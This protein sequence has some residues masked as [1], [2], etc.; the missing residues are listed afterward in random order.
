MDRR[1]ERHGFI[2]ESADRADQRVLQRAVPGPNADGHLS[3]SA[4]SDRH[5]LTQPASRSSLVS[6]ST[7]RPSAIPRNAAV[8]GGEAEGKLG[9]VAH[10]IR[11]ELEA[12]RL[13]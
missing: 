6:S 1:G 12:R 9:E 8:G 11:L 7:S 13:L 2:A 4:G 5:T 10:G 3:A